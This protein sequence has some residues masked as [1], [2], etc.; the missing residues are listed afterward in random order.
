VRLLQLGYA[1]HGNAGDEALLAAELAALRAL[2]PDVDLRVVSGDPAATERIHGV[3][4]VPRANPLAL[5]AALRWCDG[6]VVG[7]GSLLQDVTSARP[8]SGCHAGSAVPARRR[9]S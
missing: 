9:T 2:E 7:G 1:G 3:D 5:Q 6:L 4:A 8:G